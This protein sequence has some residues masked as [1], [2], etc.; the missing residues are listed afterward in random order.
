LALIGTQTPDDDFEI[1]GLKVGLASGA[2]G[3]PKSSA[4]RQTVDSSAGTREG[5]MRDLPE[6]LAAANHRGRGAFRLP[7]MP[8]TR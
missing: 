6:A 7:S 5:V 3:A 8:P 4:A 2:S 1:C